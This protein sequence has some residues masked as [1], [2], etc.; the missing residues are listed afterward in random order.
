MQA[1]LVY[2][3]A[4]K[5]I[6]DRKGWRLDERPSFMAE[7]NVSLAVGKLKILQTAAPQAAAARLN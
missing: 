1:K 2:R 7:N 4:L 6:I 3:Y 5:P